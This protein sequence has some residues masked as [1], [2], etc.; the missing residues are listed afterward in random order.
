MSI[1]DT[2]Y[3][4]FKTNAAGAAEDIEDVDKASDKAEKGLKKVDKAADGVGQ[5]FI[6]MAKQI[7]APLLALASV[8]S[9]MNLAIGRAANIRQLDA[10][11]AKLNSTVSDVDA[12]Q[13]SIQG[14]GGEGAAALDS[15][16]KIGEKVN[17][18]FS[19]KES[20]AR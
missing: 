11:S 10:V 19:D 20:G 13:R 1:L 17:E 18:A 8:G 6:A 14:L 16:V 15:L 3:I 12:F 7:A 2:F 4:L 5:S 9:L